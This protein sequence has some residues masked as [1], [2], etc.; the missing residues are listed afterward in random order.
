VAQQPANGLFAPIFYVR[1]AAERYAI[2]P[3]MPLVYGD[4][5]SLEIYFQADSPGTDKEAHWLPTPA[6]GSFN[7][8]I[9]NYWPKEVALNGVYKTP[10]VR[11]V[12]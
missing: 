6:S 12:E 1:N 2:S 3:W 7:L 8:T 11:R 10:P 9:R 5:G 4:D